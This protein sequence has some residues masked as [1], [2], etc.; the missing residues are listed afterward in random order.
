MTDPYVISVILNTNRRDDTLDCLASLL[1]NTYSH[2]SIIV[3]DNASTDGS[4]EAIHTQYPEV[5][6]VNLE[7]NR[8]Y[9]GNNNVGIQIA[10]DHGADWVFIINEDT[11]I[12][13]RC[14]TE[15]VQFGEF[16]ASIGI[17]GPMVYHHDEPG[18]IQSGG[19]L[20]G[21]YWESIHLFKDEKDIGQL[22]TVHTVE[23][24]S[25]CAIMVRKAVIEDIG[26]LDPQFFY[27]WEETDWCLRATEAGWKIIHV[28][29]AKLWH[30]GVQR[31]YNA[32]PS[33]LYY[34]TRNHL[35][36][37][38]K[39]RAPLKIWLHTLTRT[40]RTLVSWSVRPKWRDKRAYRDAM[41]QGF[42]DFLH[43]RWGKQNG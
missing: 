26:M 15:L 34:D 5:Q 19:G 4:V 40:M 37:L 16:D 22:S 43:G 38:K 25:G 6:I 41:W 3:L 1:R 42:M 24:V 11:V 13:D 30:K 17:V 39:H 21:P 29:S 23:W 7:E 33:L 32:K 18:V 28:P 9:A 27:F 20:L 10:L 36:L 2:H 31:N 8:G 35:L 14:L 12:E